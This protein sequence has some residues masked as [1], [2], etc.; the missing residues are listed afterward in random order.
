MI[1]RAWLNVSSE[2]WSCSG[3]WSGG[4]WPKAAA[5][6]LSSTGYFRFVGP[7]AGPAK[8]GP[9]SERNQ[10]AAPRRVTVW[11][12]ANTY[13]VVILSRLSGRGRFV[14]RCRS[15]GFA[16]PESPDSCVTVPL[17]GAEFY[18]GGSATTGQ[19]TP[20]PRVAQP[21]LRAELVFRGG[22]HRRSCRPRSHHGQQ[23]RGRMPKLVCRTD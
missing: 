2:H 10:I 14:C 8:S 9:V 4:R 5:R 23:Y 19:S 12:E 22:S 16:D 21:G 20:D 3:N 11:A 18:T 7:A 6:P 15:R 1:S 13:T 17:L